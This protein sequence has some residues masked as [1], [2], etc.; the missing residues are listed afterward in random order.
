MSSVPFIN[1]GTQ[2]LAVKLARHCVRTDLNAA[3]EACV[4]LAVLFCNLIAK[5]EG[6]RSAD[7]LVAMIDHAN[8]VVDDGTVA[9]ADLRV[10]R[11]LFR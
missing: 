6:I 8:R 3:T 10:E 4:T 11:G 5:E 9:I 2:K 1:S 7:L